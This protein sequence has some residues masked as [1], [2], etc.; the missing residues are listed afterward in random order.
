MTEG[1]LEK[2]H[3]ER[4]ERYDVI[5][6]APGRELYEDDVYM[7]KLTEEQEEF[8]ERVKLKLVSPEELLEYYTSIAAQY[9]L[10]DI[11]KHD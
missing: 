9:D 1:E 5:K 3:K 11:K 2:Y 8:N 10:E 7:M 4:L 6:P